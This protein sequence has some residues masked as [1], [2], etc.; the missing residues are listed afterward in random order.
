MTSNVGLDALFDNVALERNTGENREVN[1]MKAYITNDG[2]SSECFC[3]TFHTQNTTSKQ[4]TKR[5][6]A[7]RK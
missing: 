3:V 7:T 1:S 4:E 2:T 6:K 5:E